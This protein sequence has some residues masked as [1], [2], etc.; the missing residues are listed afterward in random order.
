MTHLGNGPGIAG[1]WLELKRLD[2][3]VLLP[4]EISPN[5][6]DDQSRKRMRLG[7]RMEG[8]RGAIARSVTAGAVILPSTVDAMVITGIDL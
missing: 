1:A 8:R 3:R 2:E 7:V 5:P 4:V 6:A